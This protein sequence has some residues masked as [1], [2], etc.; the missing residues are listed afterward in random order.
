MRDHLAN[1]PQLV[2]ASVRPVL[3]PFHWAALARRRR[4][5]AAAGLAAAVSVSAAAAIAGHQHRRHLGHGR[6][7]LPAQF[8]F[9][10][11]YLKKV[12]GFIMKLFDCTSS[13]YTSG[14][15]AIFLKENC[16]G[17][18]RRCT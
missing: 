5:V 10:L 7:R 12:N 1:Y 6:G 9:G 16:I 3:L 2:A 13:G 8:N 14:F 15:S 17:D 4:Q 11:L 18:C